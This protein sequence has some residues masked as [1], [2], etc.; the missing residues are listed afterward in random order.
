MTSL[1]G[2]HGRRSV[3]R[4]PANELP[5]LGPEQPLGAST[6]RAAI[7]REGD[8]AQTDPKTGFEPKRTQPARSNGAPRHGVELPPSPQAAL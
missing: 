4:E 3:L 1:N 7:W 5:L 6:V 8:V 2:G